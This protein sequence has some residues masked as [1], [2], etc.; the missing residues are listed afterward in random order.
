MHEVGADESNEFEEAMFYLG[1]LA[2]Q[3]EEQEGDQRHRDLNA[4][5]VLGTAEEVSDLQHLLHQPEEQLDLPPPFVQVSDLLRRRIELV[6]M[7][8][9]LPVFIVT[10]ISRTAHCIGFLR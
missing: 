1:H 9:R 4:D 5:R 2:Q 8:S 7:R 6:R 3:V 10:T